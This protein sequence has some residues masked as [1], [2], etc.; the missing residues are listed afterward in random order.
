MTNVSMD[1]T[2]AVT[3]ISKSFSRGGSHIYCTLADAQPRIGDVR[4]PD[5]LAA[6]YPS[7]SRA[8]GETDVD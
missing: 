2:T 4:C 1:H 6:A 8:P 7:D 5:S 3:F